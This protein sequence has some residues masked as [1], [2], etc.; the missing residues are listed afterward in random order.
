MC[1]CPGKCVGTLGELVDEK[2]K[3]ICIVCDSPVKC[4]QALEDH[5]DVQLHCV[6][7]LWEITLERLMCKWKPGSGPHSQEPQRGDKDYIR[8]H[9]TGRIRNVC[10]CNEPQ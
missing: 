10:T 4:G 2:R 7:K 6:G 5:V 8:V 1:D 3:C 9:C